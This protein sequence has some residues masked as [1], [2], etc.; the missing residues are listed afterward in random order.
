MNIDPTHLSAQQLGELGSHAVDHLARRAC[1]TLTS[2]RLL[3][4]RCLLAMDRHR[5]H[6]DHACCTSI[7]YATLVLGLK[8]KQSRQFRYVAGRLEE[9][10]ALSHQAAQGLIAWCKLREVVRVA[11]PETEEFWIDLC[12]HKTYEEIERLVALTQPGQLPAL[13][14]EGRFALHSE[15]RCRLNP[16]AMALIE[17]GLQALSQQVGRVLQLG[18]AIEM[19]FAQVL[20]RQPL[21]EDRLSEDRERALA[22][23]RAEARRDLQACPVRD[24][25]F[26]PR[27]RHTTPAQTRELQR[28]D[29]YRCSTPGCVHHLYL[30]THHIHYHSHGGKTVPENLITLCGACHRSVHEGSLRIEGQ[31]GDL[32]FLDSQGRNLRREWR[33]DV[34]EWL[35][36]WLGWD[37]GEFHTHRRRMA[38]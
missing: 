2:Y 21:D 28:R 18:E 10:P 13:P 30:Q 25:R 29:G 17:R 31:V 15:L 9:L 5:F 37:G 7:H 12:L 8:P 23:A 38:A 36:F 24:T 16:E 34:A 26:N 1:G 35:D 19:L 14:E 20:A 32:V 11:S 6:L 33:L 3:L 22:K 4:G 27:A